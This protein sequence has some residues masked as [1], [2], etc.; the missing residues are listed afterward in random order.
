MK[1]EEAWNE[2]KRDVMALQNKAEHNN[3]IDELRSYSII[4]Q[5]MK[6]L[7]QKY[8]P[9]EAKDNENNPNR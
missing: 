6:A 9:K 4:L 5:E 1:T 3:E 7:E 2:L 8:F